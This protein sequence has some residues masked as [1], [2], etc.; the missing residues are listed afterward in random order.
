MHEPRARDGS[1]RAARALLGVTADADPPQVA[2]AYRRQARHLH[3]DISLEPDA[4]E[5]FWALQAAYHLALDAAQ[6]NAPQAPAA[7][8]PV[9]ARV[10]HRDPTV[11]LDTTQTRGV[12]VSTDPGRRHGAWVVAGPVHVRPPR[13]PG[14][15]AAPGSPVV[16]S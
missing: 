13:R 7:P 6:P 11:V 8:P 15:G 5:R 3:P 2:R 12:P 9:A 14:P 1:V 4:T 10:E 16:P